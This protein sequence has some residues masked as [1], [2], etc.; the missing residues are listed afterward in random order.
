[1]SKEQLYKL[2]FE[3]KEDDNKDDELAIVLVLRSDPDAKNF[4]IWRIDSNLCVETKLSHFNNLPYA[5]HLRDLIRFISLFLQYFNTF[6]A[7][8]GSNLS[9]AAYG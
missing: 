8:D 1:M 6:G 5:L 7:K 3:S 2:R 9:F 4:K